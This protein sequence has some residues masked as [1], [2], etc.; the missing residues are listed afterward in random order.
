MTSVRWCLAGLLGLAFLVLAGCKKEDPPP[1]GG[2]GNP[3]PGFPPMMAPPILEETGPHAAG[4][5]VYNVNGCAKCHT[6]GGPQGGPAMGGPPKGGPP[7]GGP[8]GGMPPMPNKGPD[9]VKV[10]G[11]GEKRNVEW[12]VT[13]VSNPKKVNPEAKMPP[14]EKR[15]NDKDLRALAEFLASLK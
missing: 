1:Q 15:I 2:T 9:L 14:F 10:A 3:P 4:K 11:K 5:K 7:L 6:M 13:Y 8:P 12:F